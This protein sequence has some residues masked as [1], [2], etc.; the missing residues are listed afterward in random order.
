MKGCEGRSTGPGNIS[1][2]PEAR[3]DGTV[4]LRQGD[5]MLCD[6]CAEYRFPTAASANTVTA[7]SSAEL[8]V[9]QNDSELIQSELLCFILNKCNAI[10]AAQLAKLC[11]DFYREDEVLCAKSLIDR[12][13]SQRLPKRK[14]TDKHRATVDDIV[15]CCLN[16]DCKLPRFYAIDFSRIPPADM[17]HC[18]MTVVLQELQLLRQEVRSVTAL[19]AEVESLKS[20]IRQRYARPGVAAAGDAQTVIASRTSMASSSW[21]DQSAST[22]D[23]SLR[24]PP[25]TYSDVVRAASDSSKVVVDVPETGDLTSGFAEV[26]GRRGA[27]ASK[28]KPATTGAGKPANRVKPVIGA[29]TANKHVKSV[30]TTRSIDVFVSRLDPGTMEADLSDCVYEMKGDIKVVDVKCAKLKSKFETLY[31]SYH[32][33]IRVDA[34]NFNKAIELFMS[35][36]TWPIGV[37]VKRFFRAKNGEPSQ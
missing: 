32:V 29:S 35:E 19:R 8:S 6:A 36:Q 7:T 11:A 23:D 1:P 28:V 17:S 3:S 31:S 34:A 16:P 37:F 30:T 24:Q 26:V 18:D 9:N 25:K 15:K 22:Y 12:F 4:R 5:L 20:E 14:G 21:A 2:C 10:P 33:E 13:S 27:R